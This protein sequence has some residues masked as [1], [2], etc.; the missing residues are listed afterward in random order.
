MKTLTA[1]ERYKLYQYVDQN[2][3]LFEKLTVPS[4]AEKASQDLGF[5]VVAS[6]LYTARDAF[7]ITG[8][9]RGSVYKDRLRLLT[10]HVISL[11]EKLGISIPEE[12]VA[13]RDG[14]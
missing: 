11:Y 8:K 4:F 12:L 7:G 1:L 5:E 2:R 14:Q 10:K 6:H 13:L 3:N 9:A